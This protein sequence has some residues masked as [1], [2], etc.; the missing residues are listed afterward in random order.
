MNLHEFEA[1]AR[2]TIPVPT[3]TIIVTNSLQNYPGISAP[4]INWRVSHFAPG[5]FHEC[6]QGEA[7]TPEAALANLITQLTTP[8]APSDPSACTTT[9]HSPSSGTPS[10]PE[11]P[12]GVSGITLP[13][14]G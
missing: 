9:P 5:V 11:Q 7:E 1:Y 3:D 8:C 6:T 14:V 4:H 13:A 12:A 10:N 2:A